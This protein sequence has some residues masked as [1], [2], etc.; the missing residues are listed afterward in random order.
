MTPSRRIYPIKYALVCAGIYG[1]LALVWI[2]YS[3]ELAS[4]M[5]RSQA[6]LQQIEKLKG[7]AFVVV[8]TILFFLFSLSVFRR[9]RASARSLVKSQQSLIRAERDSVTGLMAATV[10]HDFSNLL[11]VL[12]LNTERLKSLASLPPA[13]QDSLVRLDR[14][15]GRLTE[16]SIR[17]RSTGRHIYKESPRQFW[18]KDTIDE[19]MELLTI[20]QSVL[21]CEISV[22]VPPDLSLKGY[23]ILIHQI[24][25]NLV[26]NAAEATDGQGRVLLR[27]TRQDD[28]LQIEVHDNGPGIPDDLR[29]RVFEAFYTTK[30]NGS[31]LGLMSV[32]SC[33]EMHRGEIQIE[34]SPMGGA[35]C[36]V[37]VSDIERAPDESHNVSESLNKNTANDAAV[38]I[39]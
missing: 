6:E 2:L 28:H 14:G 35:L 26:L 7:V 16:L 39:H 38:L 30:P 10:A 20:H 27:A 11:T 29:R 23:P 1:S 36:R 32:K 22:A 9:V 25:M 19:T 21:D 12:R 37:T 17:L 31:G 13:A 3:G 18:L 33:V 8:T 15:V 5:A 4:S 24:V 34:K